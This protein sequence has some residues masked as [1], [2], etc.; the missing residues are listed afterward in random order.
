M[1]PSL[2]LII[3]PRP[4]TSMRF[5]V[6]GRSAAQTFSA[7]RVKTAPEGLHL[8]CASN[9]LAASLLRTKDRPKRELQVH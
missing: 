5:H 6:N 8:R 4:P 1:V 7:T 2:S 3:A 9:N